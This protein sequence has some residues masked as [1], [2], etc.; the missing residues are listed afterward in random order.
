MRKMKDSGI[1]WV[2]MIPEEW[3]VIPISYVLLENKERNSDGTILNAFSFRYGSLVPKQEAGKKDEVEDTYSK[4]QIVYPGMIIVNGL[5]LSFDFVTQR[6]ALATEPGIITSTYIG[7][8]PEETVDSLFA[9]Y[10]LK[11]YDFCKAFHSMGRGLRATLAYNELKKHCVIR[12]PLPEQ[13]RIADYLDVKCAKIDETVERQK[14]VIEKLKTYKQ[15]V[16][17]EAV[18]KGLNPN[19]PMKES[20]IE[21][22]GKIPEGWEVCKL[23]NYVRMLT[24]MRDKPEDLTGEIPWVRI[25]D[26]CGKFISESKEGLG[27]SVETVQRMN[28]KIY[29]VG[30]ILCTSS[31]DLGKCAIVCRELVS[32]QRFIGIIPDEKTVPDYLY[33][34]MV[35]NEKRLNHLS[36]GTIQANL[37]RVSFE[38]LAVQFPAMHEQQQIAAY[39]DKKCAAIDMAI[40][41]KEKL[42]EKLVAY[43]KSLIYECVTGKREV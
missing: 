40:T 32:N 1:P 2:G 41:K 27:V 30:T 31:C 9:S 8:R 29:P 17:T 12:P 25:E 4:Y 6:V 36:T 28:L 39:L 18:T 19:A 15:S 35:S 43:K 16:I 42:I 13:Q 37:S 22:I 7:M 24:P 5:N 33:Y 10:L 20:G 14:A 3:D 34:L 11:S 26:Y 21:W 23:R 38:Q